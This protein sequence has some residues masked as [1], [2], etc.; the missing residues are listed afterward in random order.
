VNPCSLWVLALLLGVV[1]GAGTAS[2]SRVLIIGATFLAITAA[3][4]GAFIVG[5]FEVLAFMS[6]I[7]PIRVAVA[8]LAIG[9]ALINIKDYLWFGQGPSLTI[10][11]AAKPGI[12][13]GIRRIVRSDGSWW[14]T[15]GAT[16]ALAL[17]VTLVEL[18]CTAGM[19]VIWTTLVAD[20]GV[21]RSVFFALLGVYMAIYLLDELVMFGAAVVTLRSARLDDRGG[22]VLKLLGGAV[23]LALGIAM[24]AFPQALTSLA[25]TLLVF[26]NAL[27]FTVLV[28]LL[29]RFVHP[30]SSPLAPS[31]SRSGD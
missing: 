25:G 31:A 19:P 8:V 23:M 14:L 26:G 7:G 20:A 2:R 24:V 6:L 17:G 29:H 13:R 5:L 9:V 11:D 22:R 15:L 10:D 4:Y 27:G 1:L 30:A 21:G 18:P 16:G 3:V 12:Y 28:L